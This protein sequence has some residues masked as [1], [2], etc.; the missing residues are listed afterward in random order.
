M[1]GL[2]PIKELA[3]D[4][5]VLSQLLRRHQIALVNRS[6]ARAARLLYHCRKRL[7]YCVYLEEKCLL[8]YCVE[9]DLPGCWGTCMDEH[10]R[11]E[12]LLNGAIMRLITAR[13]RGVTDTELI[14]LID[15]EKGIKSLLEAHLNREGEALATAF[16]SI[17]DEVRTRYAQAHA[18]AVQRKLA[19]ALR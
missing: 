11:L 15:Y 3:S 7:W 6:W 9:A 4:H 10:K 5:V 14:E 16:Q 1:K 17:P 19:P 8:S 13:R 18:E 12:T 2:N